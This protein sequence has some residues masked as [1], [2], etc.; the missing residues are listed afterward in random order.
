MKI[1]LSAVLAL[2]LVGCSEDK[3]SSGK[4]EVVKESK[5][6]VAKAKE[7]VVSS[8]KEVKKVT[9]ELVKEVKKET[10]KVVE[11]V[12]TSVVKK[13]V[14]KAPVAKVVEPVKEV[15]KKEKAVVEKVAVITT[16][17]G[18]T[19]YKV[20]AGCHG[21]NA[22]KKALNKSQII[23]GWDSSKT[24]AALNGYKDGT[25]GSSMKSVM[26][27]QVSKL[28]DEKIKAVSEYISGL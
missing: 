15:A 3:A 2:F 27:G 13:P 12:K 14:Q 21:S 28:S 8:T 26:K 11:E 17:D 6:V 16:V 7:S 4:E 18:A 20:C 24:I 1:V 5:T 10:Q 25:Y 9:K 23:K 19:V 22:E